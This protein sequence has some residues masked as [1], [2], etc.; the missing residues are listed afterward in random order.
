MHKLIIEFASFVRKLKFRVCLDSNFKSGTVVAQLE[1]ALNA[2]NQDLYLDQELLP[3]L[4]S[5]QLLT[6]FKT[7]YNF[8]VE[9]T[10]T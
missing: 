1:A 5:T 3:W 6:V 8:T 9:I 7:N 4:L 10:N 2:L